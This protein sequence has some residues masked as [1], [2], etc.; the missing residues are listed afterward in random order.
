MSFFAQIPFRSPDAGMNMLAAPNTLF[1]LAPGTIQAFL[2]KRFIPK[3]CD[4]YLRSMTG[5]ALTTSPSLRLGTNG[6]HTNVCPLF[7]PPLTIA[8]TQIGAMPFAVPLF[9]PAIDGSDLILELV[10][11]AVGPTT[12]LADILLV[13]YLVA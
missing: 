10:S 2:G 5:P 3:T 12:M 13:G 8:A 9:A 11:P 6:G 1:T 4:L 7:T